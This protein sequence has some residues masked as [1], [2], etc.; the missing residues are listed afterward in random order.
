VTLSPTTIAV[1]I[2]QVTYLVQSKNSIGTYLLVVTGHLQGFTDG[3]TLAGF[4][5]KPSWISA[6]GPKLLGGVGLVGIA[7]A[8]GIAWQKGFIRKKEND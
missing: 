4:E 3:T 1:G 7:A 2:Y 6:N 5:V 8:L